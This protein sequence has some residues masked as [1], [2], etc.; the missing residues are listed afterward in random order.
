[1]LK[2][3]ERPES[4]DMLEDREAA[5]LWKAIALSKEIGESTR[6]IDLSVILELH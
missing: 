1:M 6:S 4:R 3:F 2:E 5:G